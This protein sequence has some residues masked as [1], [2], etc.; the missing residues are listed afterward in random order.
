MGVSKT[1]KTY[2]SRY[3]TDL[4]V[5]QTT[6][7]GIDATLRKISSGDGADS[8]ISLSDDVLSVQP[9]NDDT[10]ATFQVLSS[11]GQPLLSVDTTNN[12]V[13]TG[14]RQHP[15]NTQYANFGIGSP[16][17][18]SFLADTHYAISYS[19]TFL[20]GVTVANAAMGTSTTS[21]FNDTNPA[22]SLTI[23]TTA[24]DIIHSYWFIPDNITID[25]VHWFHGAD[26]A[27]GDSTAAHLM[28]YAIDLDN[29][30]TGGDLSGGIVVADGATI[31]N[32]GYEQIYYQSMTVQNADVDKDRVV[33]FTFAS[34]T[35]NS[36][37]SISA[38]VKYHI[39]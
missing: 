25:A 12:R 7:V 8:A 36:D 29:G 6:N 39:R 35:I 20:S 9:V 31:T 33:L 14:A 11:A 16:G 10:T 1:N 27:T 19:G 22:S 24:F 5:S 26:A 28:S 3:K 34:D 23:S 30:S 32:A 13:M 18:T 2:A 37:F 15:T 21:S 4:S 38:Q 17:A